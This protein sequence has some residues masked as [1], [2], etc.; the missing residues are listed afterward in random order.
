[1]ERGR[2]KRRIKEEHEEVSSRE[3]EMRDSFLDELPSREE[4][5]IEMEKL[6]RIKREKEGKRTRT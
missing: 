1:M 6:Q 3:G 5:G 4:D 2:R